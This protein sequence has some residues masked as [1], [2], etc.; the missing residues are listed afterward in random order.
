MAA[1]FALAFAAA[2]GSGVAPGRETG[3]KGGVKASRSSGDSPSA[4]KRTWRASRWP[5]S[6]TGLP[7][8]SLVII[9]STRSLFSRACSA[10]CSAPSRPCSSPATAMKTSVAS[11]DWPA[12]T[13]AMSIT[14][15]TPDA[16]SL[17]PGAV[18]L[19]SITSDA[20]ES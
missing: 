1:A 10:Q 4:N 5:A 20:R 3:V 18:M 15:A 7:M 2:I 14:A 13:Q 17:A 8:M 19:A 16:S 6:P 9:A 12:S 11:N